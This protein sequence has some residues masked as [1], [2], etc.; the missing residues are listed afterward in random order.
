MGGG[1]GIRFSFE[2]SQF[3]VE[4]KDGKLAVQDKPE[5]VQWHAVGYA[6][7]MRDIRGDLFTVGSVEVKMVEPDATLFYNKYDEG[8]EF[9]V[10]DFNPELMVWA[11]WTRGNWQDLFPMVIT[12]EASII[13]Y[14]DVKVSLVLKPTNE[15]QYFW[16]DIFETEIAE[17]NPY[18][19]NLNNRSE[20]GA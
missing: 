5:L 12:G 9:I 6:D 16:Q 20:W 1:A 17:E 19:W 13:Y 8:D 10:C 11:G 7:G 2:F 3:G 4:I 18:I 14:G 15:F